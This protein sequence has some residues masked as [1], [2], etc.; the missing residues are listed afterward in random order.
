MCCMREECVPVMLFCI[1]QTENE[2]G[3][4]SVEQVLPR[5]RE[6]TQ[7]NVDGYRISTIG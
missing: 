7:V 1:M 2:R 5:G 3:H 4:K 6:T